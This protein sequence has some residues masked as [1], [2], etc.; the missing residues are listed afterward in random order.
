MP[1]LRD[2]ALTVEERDPHQFFWVLLEATSSDAAEAIHYSPIFSA[3]A[4]QSSYASALVMGAN[5]LRK[6]ADPG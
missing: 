3:A 2:I 6:L 5:A 1:A 4:P